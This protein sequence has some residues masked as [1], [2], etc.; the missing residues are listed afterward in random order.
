MPVRSLHGSCARDHNDIVAPGKLP[1]VQPVDLAQT[2]AQ[3]V[4]LDRVAKLCADGQAD[5]VS[6]RAVSAA[7]D[8]EVENCIDASLWR[9]AKYMPGNKRMGRT[10][11]LPFTPMAQTELYMRSWLTRTA[12][13]CPWHDGGPKPCGRWR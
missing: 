3:P 10:E 7:V 9:A 13:L 11:L 12:L 6:L 4:A 2:A 8:D 5:A 1:L